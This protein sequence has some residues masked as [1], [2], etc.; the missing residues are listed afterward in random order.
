[1]QGVEYQITMLDES[2]SIGMIMMLEG[3]AAS[4]RNKLCWGHSRLHH[5]SVLAQDMS[6]PVSTNI[7]GT[8]VTVIRVGPP[9]YFTHI[10]ITTPIASALKNYRAFWLKRRFAYGDSIKPVNITK[11]PINPYTIGAAW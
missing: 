3:N 9:G 8:S 7:Y 5:S 6:M 1:M 4:F 11:T 2:W 10:S